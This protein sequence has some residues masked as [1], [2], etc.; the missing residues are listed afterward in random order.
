MNYAYGKKYHYSPCD[1]NYIQ[2]RSL[3]RHQRKHTGDRPYHCSYCD[4]KT[5]NYLINHMRIHTADKP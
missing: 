3:V 4:K 5:E 2:N 1:K